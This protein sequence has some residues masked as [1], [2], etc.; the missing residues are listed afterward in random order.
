MDVLVTIWNGFVGLV[1]SVFNFF[2]NLP[3]GA[4][5]IPFLVFLAITIIFNPKGPT[6]LS[7]LIVSVLF[8]GPAIFSLVMFLMLGFENAVVAGMITWAVGLIMLAVDTDWR[9]HKVMK[10]VWGLL[11]V[12]S[13]AAVFTYSALNPGSWS[14]DLVNMLRTSVVSIFTG[15]D[16]AN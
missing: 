13:V 7:Q 4:W 10:I 1:V 16:Q 14:T 12:V 5:F 6:P 11:A 8:A 15:Y 3:N 9:S 2:T